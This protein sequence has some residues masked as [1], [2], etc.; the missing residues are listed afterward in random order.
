MSE[1][2]M[3]PD[4]VCASRMV[5]L[6]YYGNGSTLVDVFFSFELR[7]K[8]D[9]MKYKG[10]IEVFNELKG[11]CLES[12]L[13]F[14]VTERR[15]KRVISDLRKDVWDNRIVIKF[16]TESGCVVYAAWRDWSYS[17]GLGVVCPHWI[18]P[19]LYMP[20]TITTV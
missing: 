8:E 7:S 14:S 19:K 1:V 3:L 10:Y 4:W 17:L 12:Y 6:E 16:G 11:K 15:E 2:I 18:K 9:I 5:P 13:D 20:P